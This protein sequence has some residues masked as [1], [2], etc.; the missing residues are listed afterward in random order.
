MTWPVCPPTSSGPRTCRASATRRQRASD[1]TV[2]PN[3]WCRG[4]PLCRC[5]PVPTSPGLG[6]SVLWSMVSGSVWK[7]DEVPANVEGMANRVVA[8]ALP[9]AVRSHRRY[10][11]WSGCRPRRAGAPLLARQVCLARGCL[12]D[13]HSSWS[14]PR[15]LPGQR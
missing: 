11:G 9:A 8:R 4:R 12:I 5:R 14:R 6:P 7:P 10:H 1:A 3:R 2:R 15:C 13:M